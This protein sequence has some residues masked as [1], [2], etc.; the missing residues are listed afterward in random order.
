MNYRSHFWEEM[1]SHLN[2]SRESSHPG[3]SREELKLKTFPSWAISPKQK[4]SCSLNC[5]WP[6]AYLIIYFFFPLGW[7]FLVW[8]LSL[9]SLSL[10]FRWTSS[11]W[12]SH[13]KWKK[14]VVVLRFIKTG[15][16]ESELT[17]GF[18]WVYLNTPKWIVLFF[19]S[20][21]QCRSQC[22]HL[23]FFRARLYSL[24]LR[25]VL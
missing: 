23:L 6:S 15:Y 16:S 21:W 4:S 10:S 1:D 3:L 17:C 24:L 5:K 13:L 18:C 8:P 7:L 9:I 2:K 14:T 20:A 11:I 25:H 22:L 12:L 19:F